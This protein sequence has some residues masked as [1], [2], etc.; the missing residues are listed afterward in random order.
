MDA[1]VVVSFAAR[2]PVQLGVQAA[3][4]EFLPALDI[5]AT[6]PPLP[7]LWSL[8]NCL[9]PSFGLGRFRGFALFFR[10]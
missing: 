10:L 9:W 1:S 4:G 8:G 7:L 5:L 3:C 6:L 2:E